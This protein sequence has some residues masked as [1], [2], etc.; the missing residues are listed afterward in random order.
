MWPRFKNEVCWVHFT[1]KY[2]VLVGT[3]IQCRLARATS[4]YCMTESA[5]SHDLHLQKSFWHW[6]INSCNTSAGKTPWL[7]YRKRS[8]K[9]SRDA[10]VLKSWNFWWVWKKLRVY[11]LCQK[12]TKNP[13]QASTY[14]YPQG[15]FVWR[16]ELK[17][18]GS[19]LGPKPHC[20]IGFHYR[21]Y[22]STETI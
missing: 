7:D 20:G 19:W 12:T 21:S 15:D 3:M 14:F 16:P 9:R 8:S 4:E 1:G 17:L 10:L 13:N 22:L 2:W 11:L 18:K 6:V 5:S